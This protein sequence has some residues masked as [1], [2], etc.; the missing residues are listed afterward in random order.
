MPLK[1]VRHKKSPH[2][3]IRGTVRGQTVFETTGTGDGKA[4]DALRIKREAQL[5]ERSVFGRGANVTF[6]EASVSYLESGGEGR[7]VTKLVDELGSVAVS[8]IGQEQADHVARKLYP[9]AGPSTRKR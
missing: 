6:L 5:L 9:K 1:L 2:W 3:Y 8:E 4:A 7:F